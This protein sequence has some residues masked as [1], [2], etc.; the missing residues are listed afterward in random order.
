MRSLTNARPN[1]SG[2]IYSK[3]IELLFIG[4]LLVLIYPF[5]YLI[6]GVNPGVPIEQSQTKVVYFLQVAVPLFC[7]A[8]ALMCRG[9]GVCLP[10]AIMIYPIICLAST[11]WS[12]DPYDTFKYTTLM[13]LYILAVAAVCQVLDIGIFCKIIVKVLA[14]LILASV[15]MAVAF[16]KK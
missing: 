12:V 2:L 14:F 9:P 7:I 3:V 8:I 15:V 13:F 1:I 10:G 11:M 5:F 4:L 6:S 16:K